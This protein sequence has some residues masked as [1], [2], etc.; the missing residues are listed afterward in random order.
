MIRS[1]SIIGLLYLLMFSS[2][3]WGR[4]GHQ[5]VGALAQQHHTPK[6]QKEVDGLLDGV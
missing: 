2:I 1:Y 5:E 3:Y 4:T 6:A